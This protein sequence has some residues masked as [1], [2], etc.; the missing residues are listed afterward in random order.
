MVTLHSPTAKRGAVASDRQGVHRPW[1]VTALIALGLALVAAYAIRAPG[2]W[3]GE[4]WD[5]FF[6]QWFFGAAATVG[7]VLC[8][9]RAVR[10]RQD[11]A[12]WSLIALA[13]VLEVAGNTAYT[14]LYGSTAAP[15]QPSVADAFWVAFYVPMAAA[16][17]LRVRE[18]GGAH[19]VVLDVLIAIGAL[20]AVSAAFV[21]E[22]I[23]SGGSASVPGLMTT[24]SYPVA[25][26]VLVALVMHLAAS[27]GW[28]LGRATTVMAGCFLY[29]AVSDTVY[30]YQTAHGTY[31][32]AGVLDLGWVVPF[33]LFG[34]AAWMR[35]DPAAVRQ[36]PGLRALLV[37]AGFA[38]LALVMVVY[39]ATAG[40]TVVSLALSAGALVCVI[41]RFVVTFR[42][43]LIVLQET[44]DEATTDA[45]TGLGNRRAL[46]ADLDAAF[47]G[48]QDALLLLSDLNGFKGYNDAFGH[49]AGDALLVRLG[50][51]LRDAVG[52][53]GIAYRMGGDEFCVLLGAGASKRTVSAASAAL[54]EHGV[55]FAIS[56]SH[57]RASLPAEAADAAE[58]L[59]TAD[60]RMYQHKRSARG[61]AGEQ[62]THALLRVLS[63]RHP[64]VGDHADGAAEFAETVARHMG[65]N[66]EGA[67]EVRA[68]AE[69]HDIGKAAIPDAILSK[70]GPLDADEWA[71]MRRHTLIG[72]RIVASAS[73][74]AGVSKLVRC[75]HERWDGTGYPDGLA[76]DDIPLGARIIFVCDSFDA[77][78][79]DR[80][81]SAALDF[82]SALTELEDCA[83]EQFDPQVVD[84]FVAVARARAA[85]PLDVTGPLA[86]RKLA[87]SRL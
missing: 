81:D 85:N 6:V 23:L 29:W 78:L 77:M 58:A 51:R 47:A 21:F 55:G 33:V 62:A 32:T 79:A 35:P 5:A 42:N 67:R 18:A 46:N 69:L 48:G 61:G 9:W 60:Q 26:L 41:A 27:N 30:A 64:D 83:G 71:F 76:G 73:A 24:L 10:V 13:F 57:G 74:L 12:V 70:P 25:D 66:D 43:Y 15:P 49:P 28:R 39:A 3:G 22:A 63:E 75:S 56:A 45:L 40:V 20:G 52:D 19:V 17:A 72:E 14:L 11:R 84:A 4:A 82:E 7:M 59:R 36:I 31:V 37:P 34:I 50:K 8:A 44:E 1:P 16:L 65:V 38:V 86:P 2:H 53:A 80:P 54:S 87:A 68:G